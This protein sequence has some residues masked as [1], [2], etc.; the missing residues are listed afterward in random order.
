MRDDGDFLKDLRAEIAAGQQRRANLVQV[1]LG[2]LIGIFG[3]GSIKPNSVPAISLLHIVPLIIF[4]FD[5]TL[6]AEDFGDQARG[7]VLH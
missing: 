6:I 3:L 1:K 2:A 4:V 7:S 5:L